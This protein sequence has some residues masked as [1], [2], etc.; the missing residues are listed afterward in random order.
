[1]VRKSLLF[2]SL[3]LFLFLGVSSCVQEIRAERELK[4]QRI[5]ELR[6]QVAEYKQ[7]I[8][9]CVDGWNLF[10][11]PYDSNPRSRERFDQ[12]AAKFYKLSDAPCMMRNGKIWTNP[13][14]QVDL[15][16]VRA[17]STGRLQQEMYQGLLYEFDR[18]VPFLRSGETLCEDGWISSS[19]GRGTCSW[20]GG[21]A[22]QRGDLFTFDSS[23]LKRDPREEL[24]RL[25]EK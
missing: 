1:M 15:S 13:Y 21:Y 20:H 9:D 5:A 3:F 11:S 22:Q 12:V 25:L 7:Q 17:G 14:K 10:N 16:Q 2:S 19:R 23:K 6:I 18:G 4:S 24:Q 8:L